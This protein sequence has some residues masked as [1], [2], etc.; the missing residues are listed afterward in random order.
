MMT[1]GIGIVMAGNLVMIVA[2]RY[3]LS[4]LSYVV[5]S[6]G[7]AIAT[8]AAAAGASLA[9]SADRQGNVA[10]MISAASGSGLLIA[11]VAAILLYRHGMAEPFLA[12]AATLLLVMIAIVPR[13]ARCLPR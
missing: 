12:I 2:D 8:P 3:W 9:I 11:P 13:C 6:I 5:T 1:C 7:Y 10:G 4:A